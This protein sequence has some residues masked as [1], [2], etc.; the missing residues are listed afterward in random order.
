MGR[1]MWVLAVSGPLEPFAAG[2]AAWLT[3]GVFALGGGGQ[4]VSV[5][6]AWLRRSRGALAASQPLQFVVLRYRVGRSR[7]SSRG[8]WPRMPT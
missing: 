1:K 2:F 4:A 7:L 6:S 3:S 8:I 5:R